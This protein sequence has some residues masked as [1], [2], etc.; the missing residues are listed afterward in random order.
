[1]SLKQGFS[2]WIVINRPQNLITGPIIYSM[3]V[4]LLLLD[5]CVSLY[6]ATCF[7]I[8]RV[9][10]VRRSDYI[11]FDRQQLEYLNLIQ[12]FHCS[13]CAYG[14]GLLAYA[15]EIVAR[16]EAYF[17]PIKHASKVSGAHARYPR[18]IKYGE[19]TDYERKLEK[20][21]SQLAPSDPDQADA[22]GPHASSD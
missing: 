10:K 7:P 2:R 13:Y 9:S 18:F 15:G 17:C 12:K 19:A 16:T 21:R 8:Y 20:F 5:L 4:P 22:T 6:Q 3:I 11:V 1:M 14:S